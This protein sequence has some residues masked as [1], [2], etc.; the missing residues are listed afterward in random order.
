MMAIARYQY[1]AVL[2]RAL[3]GR[4]GL[5]RHHLDALVLH[6]RLPLRLA[7]QHHPGAGGNPPGATPPGRLRLVPWG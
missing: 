1:L 3:A 5:L 4:V 6:E 7:E 2:A